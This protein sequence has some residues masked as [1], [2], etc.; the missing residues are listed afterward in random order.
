MYQYSHKF[1]TNNIHSIC[2]SE[3]DIPITLQFNSKHHVPPK[4]QENMSCKRQHH[5]NTSAEDFH[6]EAT[7]QDPL[8]ADDGACLSSSDPPPPKSFTLAEDR[9]ALDIT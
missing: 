9:I 8:G 5:Q 6:S 2:S 4:T 7:N 1:G 3:P